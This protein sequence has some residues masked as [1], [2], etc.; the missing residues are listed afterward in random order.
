MN[1]PHPLPLVPRPLLLP[2]TMLPKC[3]LLVPVPHH[4]SLARRI[5]HRL[6]YYGVGMHT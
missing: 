4:D 1:Q 2:P 3:A 6:R 5:L